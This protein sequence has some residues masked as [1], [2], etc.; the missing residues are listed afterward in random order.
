M[1]RHR[2]GQGTQKRQRISS[3]DNPANSTNVAAENVTEESEEGDADS[4]VLQAIA[5]MRQSMEQRFDNIRQDFKRELD[6]TTKKMMENTQIEV[7]ILTAKIE[8]L[9]TRIKEL[10]DNK[11]SKQASSATPAQESTVIIKHIRE[12]EDETNESLQ[13]IVTGI[14][15]ALEVE[16]TV[17]EVKRIKNPVRP[18]P[19]PPIQVTLANKNER[20]DVLHNKRNLKDTEEYK[21]VFIEPDKPRRER[22]MVANFRRIVKGIPSLSYRRGRVVISNSEPGSNPPR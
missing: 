12:E 20:N 22:E 18:N 10:E 2:S 15:A 7:G 13:D 4:K 21:S 8:R 19:K 6:A 17:Q 16:V 5:S 11:D 14:M 3:S 1:G 9:E